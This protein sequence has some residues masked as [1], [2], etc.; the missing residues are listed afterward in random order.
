MAILCFF[1]LTPVGANPYLED[2]DDRT[3]DYDDS[4]DK[5]WIENEAEIP[6]P[7]DPSTLDELQITGLPP[8]FT[9]LLDLERLAVDPV[10][11]VIRLWLVLRSKEGHDNT[12]F[13][14][15]RCASGEYRVYAYADPRR[16]PPV[17]EMTRSTWREARGSMAQNYRRHLLKQTFCGLRGAR[18][19]TEIRQAVRSGELRDP[20]IYR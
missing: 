20:L 1:A 12:S 6:P 5:P 17:R 13:E 3:F 10:D 7:P 15:Y 16:D 18:T 2:P 14:G 8:G 11:R 9:L 19:P 4:Q